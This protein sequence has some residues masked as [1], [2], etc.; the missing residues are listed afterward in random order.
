MS[1]V[2]QSIAEEIR[3]QFERGRSQA[4]IARE[5]KVHRRTLCHIIWGERKIGFGTF[6]AIAEANP[7]WLRHIFA[8]P[9]AGRMASF[10]DDD[11]PDGNGAGASEEGR[12]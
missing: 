12:T 8:Q 11:A 6:C 10:G 4:E 5:L 1:N 3:R 9:D 2:R 7:V